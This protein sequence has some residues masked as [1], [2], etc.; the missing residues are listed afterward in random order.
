VYGNKTAAMEPRSGYKVIVMKL[1]AENPT[2]LQRRVSKY[3]LKW[4]F[5]LYSMGE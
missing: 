4:K 5:V 1:Q 2:K 3:E